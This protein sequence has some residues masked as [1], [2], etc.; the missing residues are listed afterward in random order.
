MWDNRIIDKSNRLKR[1]T[2]LRNLLAG[3]CG[4]LWRYDWCKST[5]WGVAVGSNMEVCTTRWWVH[6]IG[7]A[8]I[9]TNPLAQRYRTGKLEIERHDAS[10]ESCSRCN[11]KIQPEF[12]D[13]PINCL[14]WTRLHKKFVL[15]M[16]VQ[17]HIQVWIQSLRFSTLRFYRT[18][19][20][21]V[22]DPDFNK[23]PLLHC[24]CLFQKKI[25]H[26][27]KLS[28]LPWSR[29]FTKGLHFIHVPLRPIR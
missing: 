27:S 12:L 15:P 23:Y 24:Y 9:W 11:L 22:G 26:F 18:P 4:E 29:L 17:I 5:C 16:L 19:P 21:K 2:L 14:R 7:L 13:G 8:K 6:H 28:Y 20:K 3:S 25:L 10:V 1:T